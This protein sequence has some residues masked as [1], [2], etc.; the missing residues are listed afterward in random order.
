MNGQGDWS[1]EVVGTL[2][3]WIGRNE[4]SGNVHEQP[5]TLGILGRSGAKKRLGF[6]GPSDVS[7]V[8][9]EMTYISL[10]CFSILKIENTF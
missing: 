7:S 3:T 1:S 10:S 5:L 4:D 9:L 8:T 6:E 2:G